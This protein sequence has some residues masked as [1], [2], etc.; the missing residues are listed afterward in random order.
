MSFHLFCKVTL[1]ASQVAEPGLVTE[2]TFEL[3]AK[4]E[5]WISKTAEQL[6]MKMADYWPQFKAFPGFGKTRIKEMKIHPDTFMQLAIQIA[7][8]KTHNR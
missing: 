1:D 4:L 2:L 3:D 7:A 5:Q 6:T 8:F